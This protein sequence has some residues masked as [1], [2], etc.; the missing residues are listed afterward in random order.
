[1]ADKTMAIFRATKL[2]SREEISGSVA[3]LMRWRHAA[4][5]DPD[6]TADNRIIIG[7]SNP[8]AE[9]DAALEGVWARS[10]SV[11]AIEVMISASL[12]WWERATP[13]MMEQW[14]AANVRFLVGA[15]GDGTIAHLQLHLDERTP[16]LT[17]YVVPVVRGRLN[18]KAFLGGKQKMRELQD[19]AAAAVAHLGISRGVKGSQA[20]HVSLA[21]FYAALDDKV[22]TPDPEIVPML[23]NLAKTSNQNANAA[24]EATARLRAID[25]R[26]VLRVAGLEPSKRDKKRWVDGEEHFAI[27]INGTKWFDHRADKGKGGA[28]DLVQHL[29]SCDFATARAWLASRF[30]AGQIV[31]DQVALVESRVTAEIAATVPIDFV[32]PAPS[33]ENWPKVKQYLVEARALSVKLVEAYHERGDIYAD[34]RANAVFIARDDTGKPVGA[35]LRGTHSAREYKGHALGS[36]RDR[37]VFSIGNPAAAVVVVVESAIDAMSYALIKLYQGFKDILKT[38]RIV[39]TGGVRDRAPAGTE[40]KHVLCAYDDDKAGNAAGT[41]GER[42]HPIGFK[43]W[44]NELQDIVSCRRDPAK[45]R[46]AAEA[47]YAAMLAAEATFLSSFP[48]VEPDDAGGVGVYYDTELEAQPKP[49]NGEAGYG[50]EP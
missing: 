36:R 18:A 12:E 38:T 8:L 3:H 37:G 23:V 15:F 28:I 24:K 41:W 5:A 29:L 50:F 42:L 13:E 10:D 49:D 43:D 39:S 46:I 6:R 44:N 21:K 47:E 17:G 16:H 48:E 34:A 33:P 25:L 1:M 35:E 4:N 40:R 26:D 14:I 27:T 22:E 32:P 2:K 9:I 30:D 11:R 7:S 45:A 19:K 20:S 31:A